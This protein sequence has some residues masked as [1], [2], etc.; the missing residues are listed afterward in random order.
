MQIN[1]YKDWIIR[2]DERQII[3]CK[4][5]SP[6]IDKITGEEKKTWRSETYHAT[7]GSALESM[8]N[9][10]IGACQATTIKGL[11]AKF[12]ELIQATS[13]ISAQLGEEKLHRKLKGE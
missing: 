4:E 9:K 5:G 3:L 2:S 6:S 7:I 13:E 8:C 12:H 11:Q 10:E 1:I